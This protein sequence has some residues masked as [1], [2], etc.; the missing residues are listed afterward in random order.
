MRG[1]PRII[2]AARDTTLTHSRARMFACCEY[3]STPASQDGRRP[4]T[5]ITRRRLLK[6]ATTV[7]AARAFGSRA[8]LEPAKV[9]AQSK[10]GAIAAG[11]KAL[12]YDVFGTCVDWRTGV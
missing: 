9:S 2:R 4:M 1:Q 11:V 8:V 7:A 12:V 10:P 6:G 5:H 3:H